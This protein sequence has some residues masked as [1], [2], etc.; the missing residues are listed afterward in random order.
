MIDP[1]FQPLCRIVGLRF[2][3]ASS[4]NSLDHLWVFPCVVLFVALLIG[5]HKVVGGFPIS[6]YKQAI[7]HPF[8]WT[9]W[10]IRNT[11]PYEKKDVCVCVSRLLLIIDHRTPV[12]NT[13]F[14]AL[15]SNQ[16]KKVFP[17]DKSKYNKRKK[18]DA[19]FIVVTL[20]ESDRPGEIYFSRV[21]SLRTEELTSPSSFL[22]RSDI[23]L[24]RE[25]LRFFVLVSN[26]AN[27]CRF[28]L[29]LSQSVWGVL[30]R[31]FLPLRFIYCALHRR[32]K[33][34]NSHQRCQGQLSTWW[35]LF[36]QFFFAVRV[37]PT[38]YGL[39]CRETFSTPYLP[40]FFLSLL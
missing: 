18:V 6:A 11:I 25:R 17:V 4:V 7:V 15:H 13:L 36:W 10:T 24:L 23:R 5:N 27:E 20:P 8:V 1:K 2:L 21:W 31:A 19:D 33:T 35:S 9:L 34:L 22:F 30:A 28:T 37:P 16:Q 12:W 32:S 14:A 39:L 38:G 40:L 26:R 29:S 3:I